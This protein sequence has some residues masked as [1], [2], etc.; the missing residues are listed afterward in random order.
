MARK[1]NHLHKYKKQNLS[2]NDG[3]PFLVL[4]CTK[5]DCT[6]YIAV[7]LAEGKMCECNRCGEPMFLTKAAIELTK[8]H[9]ASCTKRRKIESDETVSAV[10]S[11]LAGLKP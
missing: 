11:F 9:C 3:E 5:P 8:P 1:A 2:R 4:K 7:R 10:E 6:H